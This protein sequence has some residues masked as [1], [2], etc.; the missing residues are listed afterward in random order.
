MVFL[1][2]TAGLTLSAVGLF[3]LLFVGGASWTHIWLTFQILGFL[4]L[5]ATL[6]S[7]IFLGLA[8]AFN[9]GKWDM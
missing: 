1:R 9:F 8:L 7:V 5:A 6:V 3:L 2:V 4:I